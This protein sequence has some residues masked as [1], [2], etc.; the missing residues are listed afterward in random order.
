LHILILI[1]IGH[2]LLAAF[3]LVAAVINRGGNTVDGARPFI[4]VWLLASIANG[5]VGVLQAGIPLLNEIGAFI[6]IFGVPA[7]VAWYL[8]RRHGARLNI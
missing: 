7:A 6:P 2:L 1:V 8:S 5:A 4:W 3:V